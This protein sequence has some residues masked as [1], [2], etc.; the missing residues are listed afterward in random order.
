MKGIKINQ[1]EMNIGLNNNPFN[2][3][4]DF[5]DL[6][7]AVGFSTFQSGLQRVVGEYA[8]QDEPTVVVL[9]SSSK[10]KD[11]IIKGIEQLCVIMK[12]EC[13]AIKINN[14]EGVLVYH[15]RFKGDKLEFSNQYFIGA[16]NKYYN[17]NYK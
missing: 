8:G 9:T 3:N 13:I 14:N 12:Q 10:P 5:I 6:T 15:P 4:E 16:Y 17:K 1:V 7:R 2:S 11:V